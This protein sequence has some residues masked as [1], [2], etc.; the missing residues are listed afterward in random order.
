LATLLG[1]VSTPG[2]EFSTHVIHAEIIDGATILE[3]TKLSDS[4]TGLGKNG[5]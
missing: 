4:R 3:S 2:N 1:R 5:G